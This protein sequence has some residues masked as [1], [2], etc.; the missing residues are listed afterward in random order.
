MWYT[1]FQRITE[2]FLYT[3]ILRFIYEW[4]TLLYK[5]ISFLFSILTYLT[6]TLNFTFIA[7]LISLQYQWMNWVDRSFIQHLSMLF[8]YLWMPRW[9]NVVGRGG[10]KMCLINFFWF[11][12]YLHSQLICRLCCA[13]S[14]D[15]QK[16]IWLE[17]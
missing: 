8:L 7:Q 13:D 16:T 12:L 3:L 6:V 1:I 9:Y 4:N 14:V 11:N 2:L 15:M 17:F 5:E 10:W